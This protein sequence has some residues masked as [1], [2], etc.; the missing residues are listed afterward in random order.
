MSSS[1]AGGKLSDPLDDF[2]PIRSTPFAVTMMVGVYL[3]K[4]ATLIVRMENNPNGDHDGNLRSFD[5]TFQGSQEF[6]QGL[7]GDFIFQAMKGSGRDMVAD[8]VQAKENNGEEIYFDNLGKPKLDIREVVAF[9]MQSGYK[10]ERFYSTGGDNGFVSLSFQA[11]LA[12]DAL[13]NE[14]WSS[15]PHPT[16]DAESVGMQVLRGLIAKAQD[17]SDKQVVKGLYV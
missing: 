14:N 13:P 10:F 15:I 16:L 7:W 11:D 9:A 8:L 12:P 4:P 5:K 3:G 17:I 6:L 2:A 1:H